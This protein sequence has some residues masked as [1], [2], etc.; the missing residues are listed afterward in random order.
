M[1]KV[2][3]WVGELSTTTGA[4]SIALGG[5]LPGFTTFSTMGDGQVWY[6]IVDGDNREAGAGTLVGNILE[7]TTVYSTIFNGDYNGSNPSPIPLSGLATVFSTFNKT[8]FDELQSGLDG[9]ASLIYVDQQDQLLQ[10]QIDS[11]V[12]RTAGQGLIENG[13]ALD[14]GQGQGIIVDL[15]SVALD[16]T[17]TDALY[18]QEAIDV[19]FDPS[20]SDLTA[21]NVQDAIEQAVASSGSE[22]GVGKN[23]LI[24]SNK[25]ISQRGDFSSLPVE[26]N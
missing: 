20:N 14:V 10:D 2:G 3:N 5:P 23:L 15:S 7:R 13:T 11:I 6:A 19:P 17:Y 26:I 18:L 4:G 21:T 16:Q 22:G 25:K 12:P 1:L 8:A 24:N 9:T